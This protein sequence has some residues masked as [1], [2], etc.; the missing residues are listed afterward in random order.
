MLAQ[1]AVLDV[2]VCP[3]AGAD[4]LVVLDRSLRT[5]P[6]S[7]QVGA[8]PTWCTI[9]GTKALVVN[10]G[11][12]TLQLVDLARA[13]AGPTYAVPD[14]PW[15]VTMAPDQVTAYCISRR[16]G[17]LTAL[18]TST[19]GELTIKVGAMPR[20]IQ[21]MPTG[22]FVLNTGG[23]SISVIDPRQM[24]VLLEFPVSPIP[25]DFASVRGGAEIAVF[26]G[27]DNTIRIYSSPTGQQLARM[28]AG[29]TPISGYSRE[30]PDVLISANFGS[31]N[32]TI[33]D[34]LARHVLATVETGP[35]PLGIVMTDS[36]DV[37]VATEGLNS[38]TLLPKESIAALL[39]SGIMQR[40]FD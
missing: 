16:S 12:S 36:L 22:V 37:F 1:C 27:Q 10:N 24:E 9:F 5:A 14:D 20:A 13:S 3:C 6:R 17:T 18:N 7:I 21:L 23:N 15:R 25:A 29:D 39:Q 8:R 11:D 30:R 19:G 34:A 35:K 2:V 28:P 32:V 31:A 26:G 4:T 33:V 38:M 40:K